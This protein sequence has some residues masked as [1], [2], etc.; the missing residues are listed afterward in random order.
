MTTLPII[1]AQ[2]ARWSESIKKKKHTSYR[3]LV[4]Y[5]VSGR[6]ASL[7]KPFAFAKF[8]LT[9]QYCTNHGIHS[10]LFSRHFHSISS[11]IRKIPSIMR[12][13]HSKSPKESQQIWTIKTGS[14][15]DKPTDGQACNRKLKQQ[16]PP[17]QQPEESESHIVLYGVEKKLWTRNEMKRDSHHHQSARRPSTEVKVN[18]TL[19]EIDCNSNN[20]NQIVSVP[21]H[22]E[23]RRWF[24][25]A[26]KW[27]LLF[28]HYFIS[29]HEINKWKRVICEKRKTR[30]YAFTLA[31]TRRLWNNNNNNPST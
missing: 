2:L 31:R 14:K 13:C 17:Q 10:S 4:Y 1:F 18:Y 27:R 29:A 12:Q 5:Q 28:I 11:R 6:S 23:W 8:A 22:E 30:H 20:R 21:S 7:Q 25:R 16:P 26:R 9:H 15:A 19:I 24:A 3:R